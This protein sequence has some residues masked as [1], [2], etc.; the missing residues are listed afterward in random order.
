MIIIITSKRSRDRIREQSSQ[1]LAWYGDV[2]IHR[3]THTFL[4][5]RA[6]YQCCTRQGSVKRGNFFNGL[7]DAAILSSVLVQKGDVGRRQTMGLQNPGVAETWKWKVFLKYVRPFG[8]L[9]MI[10]WQE[11]SK[12]QIWLYVFSVSEFYWDE[13][14][15]ACCSQSRHPRHMEVVCLLST[16]RLLC[17]YSLK[18][19]PCFDPRYLFVVL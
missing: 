1:Y 18:V 12:Y 16:H 7:N 19:P 6:L 14:L 13:F 4:R 2:R 8:R 5:I 15:L 10:E 17:V 3:H 9:N 11:S